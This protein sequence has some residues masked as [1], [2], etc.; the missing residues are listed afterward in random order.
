MTAP[1]IHETVTR[2]CPHCGQPFRTVDAFREHAS[3]YRHDVDASRRARLGKLMC[4]TF[5][6]FG[7]DKVTGSEFYGTV[8]SCNPCQGAVVMKGAK[9]DIGCRS[10][11]YG[12]GHPHLTVSA[13][14]TSVDYQKPESVTVGTA[15]ERIS[16]RTDAFIRHLFRSESMLDDDWDAD[17][18]PFRPA[19]EVVRTFI[20]PECGARFPSEDGFRD[21]LRSCSGRI[22]LGDIGEKTISEEWKAFRDKWLKIT[23]EQAEEI[24]RKAVEEA[25]AYVD[26]VQLGYDPRPKPWEVDRWPAPSTASCTHPSRRRSAPGAWSDAPRTATARCPTHTRT[27]PPRPSGPSSPS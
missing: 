13:Y 22:R 21:H 7:G 8:E 5:T 24:K 25:K 19:E 27:S 16:G 11:L 10:L 23:D 14:R 18:L 9:L 2:L 20:C 17:D 3:G 15:R 4:A 1:I 6:P 12:P 26:K